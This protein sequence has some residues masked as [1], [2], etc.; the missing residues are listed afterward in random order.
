MKLETIWPDRYD[1]LCQQE[2]WLLTNDSQGC[3][4]IARLDCPADCDVG[5]TEPKYRNDWEA[6]QFVLQQ[7]IQ[8][9]EPRYVLALWLDGWPERLPLPVVPPE[10]LGFVSRRQMNQGQ[11]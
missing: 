3:F 2:G 6:K 1:L 9:H 8:T 11:K 5:F 10:L 7:A 4:T